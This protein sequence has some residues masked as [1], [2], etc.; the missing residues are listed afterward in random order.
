MAERSAG[1]D[2]WDTL[3]RAWI[4][5]LRHIWTTGEAGL[6]ESGPIIEAPPYLFEVSSLN[7]EDPLLRAHARRL[8]AKGQKDPWVARLR[9]LQGVDQ[10]AWVVEVLRA[11]PWTTRAWIS[12]TVPGERIQDVPCLTA[13]S[14][15]IVAAGPT[16]GT[17]V[18]AAMFR[19]Q[20]AVTGHQVFLS[21]RAVQLQVAE[22]LGLPPGPLRVFVEVPHIY[23]S[24][25]DEVA[26]IL[27][28]MDSGT[29]CDSAA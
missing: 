1:I 4:A 29:A 16:S 26:G 13:L 2:R 5:L 22:E 6:D 19:A 21:L 12:L 18:M 10:L 17:L 25:A 20:D 9:D 14:F 15:R 24:D 28:A 11:R 27:T 23:V 3:G 7:P 8:P